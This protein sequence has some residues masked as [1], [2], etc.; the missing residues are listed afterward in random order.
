MIIAVTWRTFHSNLLYGANIMN[1]NTPVFKVAFNDGGRSLSK[2]RKQN[3]DCTVVATAIAFNTTYD[4]AFDI[5]NIH[6]RTNNKGIVFSQFLK[7]YP[8][9]IRCIHS[10]FPH[11][12]YMLKDVMNLLDVTKTYIILIKAHTFVIKHGVI[13]DTYPVNFFQEV[14]S[15]WE[16]LKD[17]NSAD[18]LMDI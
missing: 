2:R 1:N 12:C 14:L 16:V 5:M 3:N 13:H 11:D 6:G 10:S 7:Q 18:T 4:D 15:V 17:M 8:Q 9:H